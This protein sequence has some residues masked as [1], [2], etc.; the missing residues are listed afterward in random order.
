MHSIVHVI[1]S[2]VRVLTG[3][4]CAT[5]LIEI[6]LLFIAFIVVCYHIFLDTFCGG[7]TDGLHPFSQ[8]VHNCRQYLSC[9]SE[10]ATVLECTNDPVT[11]KP[12]YFNNNACSVVPPVDFV[13]QPL[14][15][16]GGLCL[17]IC[18]G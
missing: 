6:K 11:G 7:K 8:T 1:H 13:G 10:I 16:T 2:I 18:F 5:V 3:P 9:L 4:G 15:S 12:R 14:C 17:I